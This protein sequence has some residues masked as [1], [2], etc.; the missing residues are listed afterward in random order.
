[1]RKRLVGYGG[2]EGARYAID[3]LAGQKID[4]RTLGL[5]HDEVLALAQTD[6]EVIKDE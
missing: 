4:M 5:T 6:Y 3:W 2:K 1:M